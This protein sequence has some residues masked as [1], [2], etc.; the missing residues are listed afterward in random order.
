MLGD[1]HQKDKTE[2][3]DKSYMY[4]VKDSLD[5][6]QITAVWVTPR[7]KYLIVSAIKDEDAKNGKY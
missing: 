5:N 6:S 2:H 7:N 4:R 3:K 1:Y